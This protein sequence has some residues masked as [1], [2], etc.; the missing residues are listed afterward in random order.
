MLAR[1]AQ[2]IAADQ[3]R[4]VH[5]PLD[6]RQLHQRRAADQSL[7]PGVLR[8]LLQRLAQVVGGAALA[9]AVQ[10]DPEQAL[11]LRQQHPLAG[12]RGHRQEARQLADA[13]L[14]FGQA[15]GVEQ[16][17]GIQDHQARRAGQQRRRQFVAQ[18]QDHADVVAV[19]QLLLGELLQQS[20]GGFRF[21][22]G[23]RLV[24]RL[25]GL[26]VFGEPFAGFPVEVPLRA[27]RRFAPGLAD[28]RWQ[29]VALVRIGQQ[30]E[31]PRQ[32]VVQ[33]VGQLLEQPAEQ[34]RTDL[35]QPGQG[36][37]GVGQ[38]R[39]QLVEQLVLEVFL[40]QRSGRLFAD[41]QAQAQRGAPTAAAFQQRPGRSG[42]G[43]ATVQAEQFGDLVGIERQQA[44]VDLQQLPFQQQPRQVA[45]RPPP[46][47]QPPAHPWRGRAQQAIEAGVEG[48]VGVPWVIVEQ[49]PQRGCVAQPPAQL[50]FVAFLGQAE[51]AGQAAAEGRGVQR[52]PA[53]RQPDHLHARR[54]PPRAFSEEDGLA[55]A[56]GRAEQS[57]AA[58]AAQQRLVQT[59][60]R[61]VLRRQPR[62]GGGQLGRLGHGSALVLSKR[63]AGS[64][65]R[66]CPA[67]ER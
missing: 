67:A 55:A 15:S 30:G 28:R 66:A 33:P 13:V 18:G 5:P 23:Q 16:R 4:L 48:G 2:G 65:D 14:G 57:Q 17:P 63:L 1:Q 10:E 26:A 9:A 50:R 44:A 20:G 35:R 29:A 38:R 7:R 53:Q 43:A 36:T 37:R 31:A 60:P 49:Q 47:R 24:D 52:F 46:A 32:Q 40:Q 39:R 11:P 42:I 8:Q 45:L 59:G 22:G 58:F 61:Q 12:R 54:R 56:S 27:L 21:V 25:A 34:L 51:G 19:Q 62:Q 3:P 41:Q 6:Y 64:L